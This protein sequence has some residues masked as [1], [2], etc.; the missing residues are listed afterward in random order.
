MEK[1]TGHASVLHTV[2][3]NVIGA[4][5]NFG[6]NKL[7]FFKYY[8]S[9]IILFSIAPYKVL[10]LDFF[11]LILVSGL[12]FFSKWLYLKLSV[13]CCSF[14]IDLRGDSK[15]PISLEFRF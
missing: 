9:L 1:K 6:A 12:C 11:S 14:L 10:V 2:G 15:F 7:F 3:K 13:R 4:K 5:K 8:D